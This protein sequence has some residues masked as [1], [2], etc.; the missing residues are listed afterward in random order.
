VKV[1][2]L[3]DELVI[4][5][6]LRGVVSCFTTR[7]PTHEEFDTCDRYELT[8]E[9]TVYDPRVLTYAEQKAVT[10]YSRGQLKV[11]EEEHKLRHQLCPVH[12][13]A[14]FSETTIKLQALSLKVD[15]SYLLQ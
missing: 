3:N 7:N 14:S 12:M 9:S 8:Y 2:D 4:P 5:S 11:A 10:M 13:A 6:D 15:D 1:D